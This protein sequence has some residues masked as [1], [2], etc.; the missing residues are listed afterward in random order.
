MTVELDIRLF[1]DS[2][3]GPDVSFLEDP[4]K[5]IILEK[6]CYQTSTAFYINFYLKLNNLRIDFFFI[7]SSSFKICRLCLKIRNAYTWSKDTK[8]IK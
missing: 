5:H 7:I 1:T 8:K 2:M 6:E 4:V 3:T